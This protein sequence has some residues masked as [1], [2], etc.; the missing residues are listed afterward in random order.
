MPMDADACKCGQCVSP[1]VPRASSVKTLV[2]SVCPQVVASCHAD[3]GDF[4]DLQRKH[5][6]TMV[7]LGM[8]LGALQF[9]LEGGLR[10]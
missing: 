7:H 9:Q 3:E 4:V 6:F 2:C 10:V 5:T 1:P 8:L